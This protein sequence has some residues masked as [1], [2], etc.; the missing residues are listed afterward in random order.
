MKRQKKWGRL[1]ARKR[2]LILLIILI[3]GGVFLLGNVGLWA[4]FRE[5]TY[6]GTRIL[7]ITIGSVAHD[8]LAETIDAK[9]ILPQDVTFLYKDKKVVVS[10]DTLGVHKDIERT[11]SSANK[12]KSWLPVFNLFK[13]PQLEAPIAIRA[14]TFS[15]QTSTL[16]AAFHTDP[17]NAKLDVVSKDSKATVVIVDEQAGHDLRTASLRELLVSSLDRGL[18]TVVV[19]VDQK[20]PKI[21]KADLSDDQ[22]Q[23]QQQVETPVV[24]RYNSRVKQ[25]SSEKVASWFDFTKE[26]PVLNQQAIERYIQDTGKEFGIRVKDIPGVAASTAQAV[27]GK[28]ALDSTLVQQIALKTFTYC[29]AVRGVEASHLSGLKS[30]VLA[31]LNDS[32]G[33]SVKGLVEFKEVSASCDFTVWLSAASLMPTF[34]A[35]CD[36][37]WS[38]RV[39]SNVVI[40]FDRWQGA[41]PSWN[42]NGGSLEEYRNMVINHETGHWLSFGHSHCPGSGQSAPVMQQQS[43]DL[44]GCTF[45]PWPTEGEITTL[46]RDLSI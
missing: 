38:C 21:T 12:Q 19:A 9:E 15:T 39:G 44:Q 7:D 30:R 13:K 14:Q 46:R 40:N 41:S 1:T 29:T 22:K 20:Q 27:S 34:G 43:I 17:V 35:I 33:W 10:L 11:I 5:R 24:Y 4:I 31:T 2:K 32:R 23:I 37:M 42:A 26:T 45:N 6:P 18:R 8:K 25:V 28:K 36:S 16:A 3:S